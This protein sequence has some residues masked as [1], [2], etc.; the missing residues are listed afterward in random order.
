MTMKQT[1]NTSVSVWPPNIT[2]TRDLNDDFSRIVFGVKMADLGETEGLNVN[3]LIMSALTP[4]G[5]KV[6]N[7]EAA[8]R[9]A[10]WEESHG[11][12]A[13]FGDVKDL[14]SDLHL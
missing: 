14:L 9:R 13:E 11:R 4:I 12:F 6:F 3:F 5:L 8:E 2:A 10:D 7:W 1:I